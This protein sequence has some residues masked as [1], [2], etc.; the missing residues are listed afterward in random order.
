MRGM[1]TKTYIENESINNTIDQKLDS[2]LN[3]F[4]LEDSPYTKRKGGLVLSARKRGSNTQLL[5]VP[6]SNLP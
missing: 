3:K 6:D 5:G 1:I 4:I 2:L